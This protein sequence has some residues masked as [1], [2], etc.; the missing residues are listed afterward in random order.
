MIST[1]I[2]LFRGVLHRKRL[3]LEFGRSRI[4]YDS[5]TELETG[6]LETR[7]PPLQVKVK[8]HSRSYAALRMIPKSD[9]DFWKDQ[10]TKGYPDVAI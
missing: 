3:R 2:I 6:A 1:K 4:D 9:P 8:L 7:A 10:A 5:V